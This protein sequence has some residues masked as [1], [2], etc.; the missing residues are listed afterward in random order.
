MLLSVNMFY[1]P[2]WYLVLMVIVTIL[3]IAIGSWWLK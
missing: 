3:F 1:V 2:D